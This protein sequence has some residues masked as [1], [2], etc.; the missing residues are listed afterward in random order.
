MLWTVFVVGLRFL[1]G[2][3]CFFFTVLSFFLCVC[4]NGFNSGLVPPTICLG[5]SFPGGGVPEGDGLGGFLD[6]RENSY[7]IIW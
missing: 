3:R 5:G 4:I 2:F 7:F 6:S 1:M